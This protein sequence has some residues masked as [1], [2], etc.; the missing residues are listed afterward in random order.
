MRPCGRQAA[1]GTEL[2]A[3][4]SGAKVVL[5]SLGQS[6][7]VSLTLTGASW[8]PSYSTACQQHAEK[9][10]PWACQLAS[11]WVR[12]PELHCPS[13]RTRCPPYPATWGF[14]RRG[15]I[16]QRSLSL[17]DSVAPTEIDIPEF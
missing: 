6:L 16:D 1:V 17:S 15:K 2:P 11:S 8:L 14:N 7:F 5:V 3:G 4:V 10:A 9:P 12:V 13:D